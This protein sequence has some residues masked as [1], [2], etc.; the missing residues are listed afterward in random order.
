ISYDELPLSLFPNP[1]INRLQLENVGYGSISI[2]SSSGNLV[3][4]QEN[5]LEQVDVANLASGIYLLRYQ[6]EWGQSATRKFVKQ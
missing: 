4:T 5:S 2:F 1:V 3:L 6:N